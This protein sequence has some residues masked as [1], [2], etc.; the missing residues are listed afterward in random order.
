[1]VP[2]PT[3]EAIGRSALGKASVRL[4]PMIGVGYGIAYM[5]RVNVSFA[6]LQMNQQLHFSQTVFGLGA[7]L[8]FLSYAACEIPSNLLLVRFGARRWL[9]RIMLT[10]GLI[11]M[12][13]IFVRTPLEFYAGRLLL[14]VAEAGFFPGVIFYLSQWFP[15]GERSKAVSRFYIA[16][17]LSSTVMGGLA[18]WLLHLD[19]HARLAGWQWLLLLEGLPAV[20]MSLVFLLGLPDGPAKA[21]WLTEAERNWI[22]RKLENEPGEAGHGRHDASR[23]FRDPR[24][25]LLGSFFF[26]VLLAAYGYSFSAPALVQQVTRLGTT[27]VGLI[28]AV[29][30]V[31][32]ALAMLGNGAHSDRT[33]ERYWHI[34]VPVFVMAAGFVGAGLSLRPVV[35]LPSLAVMMMGFAAMQAPLWTIPTSF[36]RGRS[37]AAGIAVVNTIGILGGFVGPYWMG[38]MADLTGGFQRGLLTLAVPIMMA[39]GLIAVIHRYGKRRAL[40][41]V[42]LAGAAGESKP[43]V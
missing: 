18:G 6:A 40:A 11:S 32:G 15:A 39:A 19:G 42:L 41:L 17:P 20:T 34:A 24:V 14:G 28:I 7:G 36:L 37:A 10:W 25:W 8:F 30:G 9:A 1:M 5:D 27:G 13:M 26:C 35:V 23:A 2:S 3:E 16:Y 38:A 21:G 12:A 4:L 22:L 33:G 43:A 29:L 31:L